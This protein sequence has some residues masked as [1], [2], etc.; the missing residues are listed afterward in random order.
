MVTVLVDREFESRSGQSKDYNTDMR[1]FSAK[2]ATLK[3]KSKNWVS[4]TQNNVS[5]GSDMST[6][7]LLFW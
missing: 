4:R 6:R 2:H 1:C 3:S 5:Q 7:G